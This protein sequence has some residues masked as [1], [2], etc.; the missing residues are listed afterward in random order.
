MTTLGDVLS[1][2]REVIVMNERVTAL[3][4]RLDKLDQSHGELRDRVTRMEAFFDVIRPMIVRQAIP[5]PD[6]A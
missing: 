3:T 2:V 1:A 4:G 5:S 6:A